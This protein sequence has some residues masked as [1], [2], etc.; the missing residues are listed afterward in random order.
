MSN[1]EPHSEMLTYLILKYGSIDNVYIA[2]MKDTSGFS[3]EE[4]EA[5]IEIEKAKYPNLRLIRG[6]DVD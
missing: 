3:K 6:I 1:L 2:W 4:E 5:I